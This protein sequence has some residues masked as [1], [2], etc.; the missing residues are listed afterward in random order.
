MIAK[1]R[2]ID[3]SLATSRSER[4]YAKMNVE[5]WW[6]IKRD[7]NANCDEG[8]GR[9]YNVNDSGSSCVMMENTW[10]DRVMV[11]EEDV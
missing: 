6:K 4:K 7:N 5:L 11:G 10:G 8:D 9:S 1:A 2:F 3:S